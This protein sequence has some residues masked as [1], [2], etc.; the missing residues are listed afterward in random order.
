MKD[1]QFF[2]CSHWLMRR[3]LACKNSNTVL[4]HRSLIMLSWH[5][6]S[7]QE[8][9]MQYCGALYYIDAK[10]I[11][12]DLYSRANGF[13][14]GIGVFLC[15]TLRF[16]M[17]HRHMEPRCPAAALAR[18][19]YKNQ[20]VVQWLVSDYLALTHSTDQSIY[21]TCRHFQILPSKA[22]CTMAPFQIELYRCHCYNR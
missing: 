18:I 17:T 5:S 22:A 13:L 1:L 2:L 9:K 11:P 20:C 16:R 12:G 3:V 7:S 21:S 15:E 4:I 14:N 6:T 10:S 8:L 19:V